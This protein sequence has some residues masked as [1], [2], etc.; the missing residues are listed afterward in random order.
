M[1]VVERKGGG[2]R[3]LRDSRRGER[4][5]EEGKGTQGGTSRS[6]GAEKRG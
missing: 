2:F 5:G 6:W 4:E 1:S 3:G